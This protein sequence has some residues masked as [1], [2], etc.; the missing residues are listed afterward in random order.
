MSNSVGI[1]DYGYRGEITAKVD[2]LDD[3]DCQISR[4]MRLFQLCAPDL[5]PLE[6]EILESTELEDSARGVGGFGRVVPDHTIPSGPAAM[7][8]LTY[9]ALV[10]ALVLCQ[11][12]DVKPDTLLIHPRQ[13]GE[14]MKMEE[15]YSA[16]DQAYVSIPQRLEGQMGA[17]I[18]YIG[19]IVGLNIIVSNNVVQGEALVFD[20]A[21]YG[22]L[23]VRQP[24][25]IE[26]FENAWNQTN[27][28]FM[29]ERYAPACFERNAA[30]KIINLNM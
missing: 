6:I 23:L 17:P 9:D 11:L 21:R 30:S 3:F 4:G 19:S 13:M 10:D 15:F 29:T 22:A 12:E 28:G 27:Y 7:N 20:K 26:N 5:T 2:N 24:I 8:P 16:F 25:E 1:I 18:G 14:L